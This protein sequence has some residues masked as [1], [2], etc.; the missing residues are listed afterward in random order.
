[1]FLEAFPIDHTFYLPFGSRVGLTINLFPYFLKK[2]KKSM[3]D[4]I[5]DLNMCGIGNIAS[6]IILE[7]LIEPIYV[8]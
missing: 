7:P 3:A 8:S 1:L 5:I 2:K 4:D 6:K